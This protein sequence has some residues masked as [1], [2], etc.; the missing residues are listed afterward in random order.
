MGID[1]VFWRVRI[2]TFIQ[3]A[4]C[5]SRIP[6]L[7]IT[8]MSLYIRTL[9]FLLLAVYGVETNPGPVNGP[10]TLGKGGATGSS[11]SK[12]RGRGDSHEVPPRL[13]RSNSATTQPSPHVNVPSPRQAQA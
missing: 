2:G 9:L 4:K 6:V 10:G 7:T 1:I 11:S 5:H 12:G 8:G 3:P 13:L